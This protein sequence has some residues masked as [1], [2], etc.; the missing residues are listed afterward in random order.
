MRI[1]II[2]KV[3]YEELLRSVALVNKRFENLEKSLKNISDEII[4]LKDKVKLLENEK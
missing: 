1:E 3:K 4:G 2:S